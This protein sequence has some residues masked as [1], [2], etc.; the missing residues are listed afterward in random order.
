MT[1]GPL[2][3][4]YIV[5]FIYLYFLTTCDVTFY[6]PLSLLLFAF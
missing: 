6:F 2:M 4:F 5:V 1:V 3:V